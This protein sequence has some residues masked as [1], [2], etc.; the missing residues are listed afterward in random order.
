MV[1]VVVVVVVLFSWIFVNYLPDCK[2]RIMQYFGTHTNQNRK[3]TQVFEKHLGT[4]LCSN[5]GHMTAIITRNTSTS[6][7]CPPTRINTLLFPW[8]MLLTLTIWGGI[9]VGHLGSLWPVLLPLRTPVFPN[10]LGGFW[11]EWEV[12]SNH[13]SSLLLL[14]LPI[15]LYIV[16]RCDFI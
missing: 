13:S 3:T 2:I 15:Y 4:A 8:F 6:S 5:T 16:Q 9:K 10:T 1:I 14:F 12:G 11:L 7:L